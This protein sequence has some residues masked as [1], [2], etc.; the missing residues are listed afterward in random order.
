MT[1]LPDG[2]I[3]VLVVVHGG[4]T[5]SGLPG[6]SPLLRTLLRRRWVV[7]GALDVAGDSGVLVPF[8]RYGV[9]A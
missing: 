7:I 4:E 5:A 6:Y 2:R 9:Y 8:Y 3:V 1:G